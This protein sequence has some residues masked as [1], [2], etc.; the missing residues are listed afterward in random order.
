MVNTA[1]AHAAPSRVA[2]PDADAITIYQP[3]D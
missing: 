1:F 3:P 2:K